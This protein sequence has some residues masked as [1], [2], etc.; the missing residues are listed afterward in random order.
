[1]SGYTMSLPMKLNN[2]N[3][4]LSGLQLELGYDCRAAA[5]SVG[6]QLKDASVAC[7]TPAV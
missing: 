7:A 2:L 4:I 1:M 6:V 5:T 3:E